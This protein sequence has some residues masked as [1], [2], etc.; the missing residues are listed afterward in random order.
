LIEDITAAWFKETLDRVSD[1]LS[2]N[3]KSLLLLSECND[4]PRVMKEIIRITT[5]TGKFEKADINVNIDA[6]G[7]W[8]SLE[9]VLPVE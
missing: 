1:E 6:E 3:E 5:K 8:F 7:H 4:D 9:L 2:R